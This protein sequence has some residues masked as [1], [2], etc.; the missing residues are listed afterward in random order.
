[1]NEISD[2]EYSQLNQQDRLRLTRIGH[3]MVD[4]R[5]GKVHPKS[6]MAFKNV[7]NILNANPQWNFEMMGEYGPN[8]SWQIV[9]EV[10]KKYKLSRHAVGDALYHYY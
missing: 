9:N 6:S 8:V 4:I 3:L 7:E 10:M 1:M 2:E 5:T